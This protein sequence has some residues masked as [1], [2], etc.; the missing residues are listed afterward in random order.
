MVFNQSQGLG[1]GRGG[2]GV[3][4]GPGMRGQRGCTRD[5]S[6]SQQGWWWG[7]GGGSPCANRRYICD[8]RNPKGGCTPAWYNICRYLSLRCQAVTHGRT[9]LHAVAE[10]L[11]IS[12]GNNNWVCMRDYGQEQWFKGSFPWEHRVHHVPFKFSKNALIQNDARLFS[13]RII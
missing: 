6:I 5:I 1:W 9:Q 3:V 2:G 13:T 7:G 11:S 12:L 10:R 8:G 4:V